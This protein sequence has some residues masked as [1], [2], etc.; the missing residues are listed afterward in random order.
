MIRFSSDLGLHHKH[1]WE[2]G[3]YEE[4][5][6]GRRNEKKQIKFCY[7]KN[8]SDFC[9]VKQCY[10]HLLIILRYVEE[11]IGLLILTAIGYW[12]LKKYF[13]KPFKEGYQY[14]NTRT[15]QSY[16]R[17]YTDTYELSKEKGDL[18]EQFVV[19]KFNQNYFKIKEWRGDKYIDGRYAESNMNPDLEVEFSLQGE[20]YRFAVECKYRT[21]S[22][23]GFIEIAKDRQLSHY[24][25]FA[26][27]KSIEVYIA[28]GLGGKPD[29]PAEMFLIPL[30]SIDVPHVNIDQIR[31]YRRYPGDLFFYDTQKGE[32]K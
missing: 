8:N 24:K 30:Q 11:L 16:R 22:E 25:N 13:I 31:K 5:C 32:L 23:N 28:L 10:S 21:R 7:P 17:S 12:L 15:V 2:K 4:T 20:K 9:V 6:R 3:I 27:E 1:T 18:F 29:Y 26:Q 14:V 19:K